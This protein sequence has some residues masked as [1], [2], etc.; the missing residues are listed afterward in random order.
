M[1]AAPGDDEH[2]LKK[3]TN[4]ID[5]AEKSGAKILMDVYH[6]INIIVCYE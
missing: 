2:S 5:E 4:C 1:T 6:V 3:I